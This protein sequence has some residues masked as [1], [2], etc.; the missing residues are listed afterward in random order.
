MWKSNDKERSYHP[1]HR[2][3]D[4]EMFSPSKTSPSPLLS[5]SLMQSPEEVARTVYV[6]N[7]LPLVTSEQILGLFSACGPISFFRFS[8]DRP[9]PPSGPAGYVPVVSRYCFIEFLLPEGFAN[10]IALNGYLFF[11]RPLKVCESNKALVRSLVVDP[12]TVPNQMMNDFFL[13]VVKINTKLGVADP[14]IFEKLS[15]TT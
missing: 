2:R 10:A 8:A 4:P 7:L 9:L 13:S 12:N 1:R 11:G 14:E 3:R 5:Y 15:H 6:G